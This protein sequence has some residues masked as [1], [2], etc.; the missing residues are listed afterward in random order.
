MGAVTVVTFD[1]VFIA[2]RW[3]RHKHLLAPNT[4]TWQK[5]LSVIAIIFAVIG[6]VGLVLLTIFDN[7]HHGHA[8]DAFLVVFM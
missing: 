6:A 3:F 7:L 4:S 1:V 2:E 8:H 5:I